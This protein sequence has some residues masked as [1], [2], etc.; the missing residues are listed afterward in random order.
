MGKKAKGKSGRYNLGVAR[1]YTGKSAGVA[2]ADKKR[3]EDAVAH[4]RR[5]HKTEPVYRLDTNKNLPAY[6]FHG[7]TVKDAEAWLRKYAW[8]PAWRLCANNGE[9]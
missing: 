5:D 2:L 4:F 7:M 3:N 9:R 6:D 8:K 1:I